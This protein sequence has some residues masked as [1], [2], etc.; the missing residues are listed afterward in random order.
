MDN[1]EALRDRV[2]DLAGKVLLDPEASEKEKNEI[3]FVAAMLDIACHKYPEEE[4]IKWENIQGSILETLKFEGCNI[5]TYDPKTDGLA[6]CYMLWA[7]KMPDPTWTVKIDIE[8][9]S[10]IDKI[11][12]FVVDIVKL[13]ED[14]DEDNHEFSGSLKTIEDVKFMC[15]LIGLG[16]IEDA[17][18]YIKDNDPFPPKQQPLT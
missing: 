13:G 10:S 17:K 9:S 18:T 8:D 12:C 14:E 16:K 6:G 4:R 11:S 2:S 5:L 1:L 15:Q 7:D 3:S